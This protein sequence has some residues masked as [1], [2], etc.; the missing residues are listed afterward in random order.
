MK[1]PSTEKT[2]D[3]PVSKQAPLIYSFRETFL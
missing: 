3:S 2:L 1:T